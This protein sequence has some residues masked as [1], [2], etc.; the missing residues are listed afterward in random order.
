[1]KNNAQEWLDKYYPKRQVV[2]LKRRKASSETKIITRER[3][4]SL[5]I[6]KQNLSGSLDLSDF[7]NLEVLNC[8]TNYLY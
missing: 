5:N 8:E 3:I 2:L 1:M 6:K 7:T 4:V